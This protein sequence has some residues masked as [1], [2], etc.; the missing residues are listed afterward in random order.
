MYATDNKADVLEI[1]LKL[2][3][4]REREYVCAHHMYDWFGNNRNKRCLSLNLT[5]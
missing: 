4:E 5:F 2:E 1:V 3:R